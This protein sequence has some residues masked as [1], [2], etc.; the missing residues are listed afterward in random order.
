MAYDSNPHEITDKIKKGGIYYSDC[1]DS[2]ESKT[3]FGINIV[4]DRKNKAILSVHDVDCIFFTHK[5]TNKLDK[6]MELLNDADLKIDVYA[7]IK[8]RN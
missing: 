3:N 7:K 4:R 6:L 2:A 1:I 5:D 8:E